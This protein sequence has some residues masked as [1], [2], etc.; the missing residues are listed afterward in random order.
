MKIF[1]ADYLPIKNKGEEAILR[2]IQSLYQEKFQ[3]EIE[4]FVFGPNDIIV[5][6]DNITSFPVDWCYPMYKKQQKFI[7]RLGLCRRLLCALMYRIGIFPYVRNI[8][9]HEELLNAFKS[10]DIILLAHDG[11]YNTFCAGLGLFLKKND[12]HYAVPGTGFMPLRK[13]DFFN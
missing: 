9:K 12:L 8:K 2:G 10:S 5:K 6:H 1:I 7:G 11:F 3:K 4:F 13:Y